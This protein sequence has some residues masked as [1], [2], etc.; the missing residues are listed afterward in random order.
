MSRGAGRGKGPGATAAGLETPG[1]AGWCEL[2]QAVEEPGGS[3][4]LTRTQARPQPRWDVRT[5]LQA[6]SRSDTRDFSCSDHTATRGLNFS[7]NYVYDFS[8]SM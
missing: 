7:A 5:Q 4:R 2:P 1:G 8:T 6:V 3:W